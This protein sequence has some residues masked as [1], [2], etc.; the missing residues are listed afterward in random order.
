MYG[1]ASSRGRLI[2]PRKELYGDASSVPAPNNFSY[3]YDFVPYGGP[4]SPTEAENSPLT[5]GSSFDGK[6]LSSKSWYKNLT[7]NS[8]GLDGPNSPGVP[9]GSPFLSSGDLSYASS[10]PSMSPLARDLDNF[11]FEA[12]EAPLEK[13]SIFRPR[14]FSATEATVAPSD[15]WHDPSVRPRSASY[16]IAPSTTG[17]FDDEPFGFTS[18]LDEIDLDDGFLSETG[19]YF[20][21][22]GLTSF[23]NDGFLTSQ[24]AS[25]VPPSVSTTESNSSTLFA[26]VNNLL[27]APDIM[28]PKPR[29]PNPRH[30]VALSLDTNLNP[31]TKAGGHYRS[32]SDSSCL[33]AD[34]PVD[35]RNNGLIHRSTLSSHESRRHSPYP[36]PYSSPAS[37]SSEL[38]SLSSQEFAALGITDPPYSGTQGLHRRSTLSA[39]ARSPTLSADSAQLHR[40]SSDPSSTR[41]GPQKR[42]KVKPNSSPGSSTFVISDDDSSATP[43]AISRVVSPSESVLSDLPSPDNYKPIVAS[44]KIVQASN[45]RRTREARFRCEYEGCPSTFTA[46]HNLRSACSLLHPLTIY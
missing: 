44:Q 3:P 4:R 6:R 39:A 8:S 36:S 34:S 29:H 5:T 38:S 31:R 10:S 17:V 13:P 18:E 42:R 12:D 11:S 32:R 40:F 26:P 41:Y 1:S 19:S 35:R 9:Y 43:D 20:G 15:T 22:R 28:H 46:K 14:S 37:A 23:S 2:E 30:P 16:S 24:S 7:H 27:T 25:P 21:E 33:S 45:S